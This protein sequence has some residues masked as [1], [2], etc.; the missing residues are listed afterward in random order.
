MSILKIHGK[1]KFCNYQEG[2][3][4]LDILQ[5][6]GL[7]LESPC[8]GKGYCGKC[9]VQIIEGKLDEPT[10]DELKHLSKKRNR[11]RHKA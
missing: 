7:S 6:S 9:K 3:S 10:E 4:L 11:R 2:K 5:E 8:G 1:D